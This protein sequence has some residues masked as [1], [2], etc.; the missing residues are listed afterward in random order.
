MY[1]RAASNISVRNKKKMLLLIALFLTSSWD[2]NATFG[3]AKVAS[4]VLTMPPGAQLCAT[5]MSTID[6]IY[7]SYEIA[8]NTLTVFDPEIVHWHIECGPTPPW[9]FLAVLLVLAGIALNVCNPT[10]KPKKVQ[11]VLLS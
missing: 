8:N 6:G 9:A 11:P 5:W 2:V 4:A 1:Q 7:S 10:P 3:P